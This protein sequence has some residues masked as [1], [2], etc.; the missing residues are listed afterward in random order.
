MPNLV[1]TEGRLSHKNDGISL[2]LIQQ[3]LKD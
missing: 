2:S 1:V 3:D